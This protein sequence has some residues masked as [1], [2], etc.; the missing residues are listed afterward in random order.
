LHTVGSAPANDEQ[1][2]EARGV[3]SSQTGQ[4]CRQ[5]RASVTRH[6][7]PLLKV[8]HEFSARG[9]SQLTSWCYIPWVVVREKGW[10]HD[11]ARNS[12]EKDRRDPQHAQ[13]YDLSRPAMI[14]QYPFWRSYKLGFSIMCRTSVEL[15]PGYPAT[16]SDGGLCVCR[17]GVRR[18]TGACQAAIVLF[19]FHGR[20]SISFECVLSRLEPSK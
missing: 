6:R 16:S 13:E 18:S 5:R 7:R 12:E 11:K 17:R 20:W 15:G 8:S 2:L 1:R 3:Q 9:F 14:D 10:G 19:R 4:K